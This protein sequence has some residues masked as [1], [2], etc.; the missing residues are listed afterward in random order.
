[1]FFTKYIWE[2][3]FAKLHIEK[4]QESHRDKFKRMSNA[5]HE[6]YALNDLIAQ[7]YM[8]VR[9]MQ[10]NWRIIFIWNEK[11]AN[12]A[13]ARTH[14]LAYRFRVLQEIFVMSNMHDE[15]CPFSKSWLKGWKQIST[16][17]Q[18]FIHS[19]FFF[20]YYTKS[21]QIKRNEF[22]VFELFPI[23][24]LECWNQALLFPR[25]KNS[26]INLIENA[27]FPLAWSIFLR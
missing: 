12:D 17:R 8:L 13:I 16:R 20:I 7:Q 3:I 23:L 14:S 6:F 18:V 9:Q 26:W 22:S 15:V 1:M 11:W 24:K 10:C 27:V 19:F 5:S 25:Q 4:Y 21:L 2:N